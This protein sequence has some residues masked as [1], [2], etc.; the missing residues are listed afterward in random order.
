MYFKENSIAKGKNKTF[1]FKTWLPWLQWGLKSAPAV[2]L[3]QII[4]NGNVKRFPH[5]TNTS[6]SLSPSA[7]PFLAQ[8]K[9]IIFHT[10]TDSWSA[11][12]LIAYTSS[13]SL[14]RV[15]PHRRK[16]FLRIFLCLLLIAASFSSS[17][18][19]LLSGTSLYV[20]DQN[21]QRI[22]QKQLNWSFAATL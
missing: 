8:L 11:L 19:L 10:I 15:S 18:V 20:W 17:C 5:L 14:A 9:T 12:L 21:W 16:A 7:S 6:L 3:Q 1:P 2:A 22:L 13:S 4:T